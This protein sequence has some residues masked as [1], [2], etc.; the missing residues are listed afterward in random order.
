MVN[1]IKALLFDIRSENPEKYISVVLEDFLDILKKFTNIFINVYPLAI[2]VEERIKIKKRW[3]DV[4]GDWAQSHNLNIEVFYDIYGVPVGPCQIWFQLMFRVFQDSRIS[5]I[6]YLPYDIHYLTDKKHLWSFVEYC[7]S[8]NVVDIVLG[9]YDIITEPSKTG[10]FDPK[11]FFR[12]DP[13]S[14]RKKSLEYHCLLEMITHFPKTTEWWLCNRN[15]HKRI[16]WPR[17][18]FFSVN[19]IFFDY[20]MKRPH[21]PFMLPYVGTV[22]MLVTA[23]INNQLKSDHRMKAIDENQNAIEFKIL[24]KYVGELKQSAEPLFGFGAGHQLLRI[25]WAIREL[26]LYYRSQVP[27]NIL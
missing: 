3:E 17:T 2:T 25:T 26:A 19:K 23:L 5:R 14:I 12:N 21:R 9:T 13:A 8:P 22:E 16:A 27:A 7:L 20:F 18:G 1:D 6:C 11:I 15:D 4:I 24:D 10:D